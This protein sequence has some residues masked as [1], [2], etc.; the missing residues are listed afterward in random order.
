MVSVIASV[1][2]VCPNRPLG[3]GEDLRVAELQANRLLGA[4]EIT[5]PSVPETL[6]ASLPRIQVERAAHLP[7]SGATRW[8]KGRWIIALNATDSVMRQRF[9]LVHEF[10]HVIDAPFGE[11]LYPAIR[12]WKSRARREQIADYF[13]ACVLMP[14]MWVKRAWREGVQDVDALARIFQVSQVAMRVRLQS[15]GLIET[16]P[17]CLV[18]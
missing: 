9:S 4:L 1:R 3:L 10:K 12:D 6:I 13:A 17:R 8:L 7:G 11:T 15:I 2:A 5:R 16:A 14:R 18:A